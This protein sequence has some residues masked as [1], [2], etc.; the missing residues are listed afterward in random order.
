ML[1]LFDDGQEITLNANMK[2]D[3]SAWS[4]M[5]K[6]KKVLES[7]LYQTVKDNLIVKEDEIYV[8]VACS[9]LHG[10][11]FFLACIPMSKIG[12]IPQLKKESQ[13]P[14]YLSAL[15]VKKFLADMGAE[16]YNVRQKAFLRIL[17]E[18]GLFCPICG[19]PVKKYRINGN[20]LTTCKKHHSLGYYS[21]FEPEYLLTLKTC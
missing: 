16:V 11:S 15:I 3:L 5:K 19:L 12:K 1:V 10:T 20:F 2:T 18:K 21:D 6:K 8:S 7:L 9:F 14:A 13:Y 17:N 4:A